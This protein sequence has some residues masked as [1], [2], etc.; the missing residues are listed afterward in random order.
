MS[1]SRKSASNKSGLLG[2]LDE[3]ERKK[4]NQMTQIS[5]ILSPAP[6]TLSN[7]QIQQQIAHRRRLTKE[8]MAAIVIQKNFRMFY[9][10]KFFQSFIVRFRRIKKARIIPY[11]YAMLL[12]SNMLQGRGRDIYYR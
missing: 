3:F 2:F 11:Y 12:N 6:D 1:V 9:V 4:S 10:H 8:D 7:E 5:N